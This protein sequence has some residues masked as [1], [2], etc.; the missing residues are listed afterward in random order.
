M[1]KFFKILFSRIAFLLIAFTLQI[2]F[3]IFS[4]LEF[5][6]YFV[7]F[8]TISIVLSILLVLSLI[9]SNIVPEYK[10]AWIIPIMLFPAFGWILYI[11][12]SKPNFNK[13][14]TKRERDYYKNMLQEFKTLHKYDTSCIEELEKENIVALN[15]AK[16]LINYGRSFIFNNSD[17]KYYSV[18][19]EYFES[20]LKE[21]NKAE[22]FIFMEYFIIQEG[23]MWDS[24]LE[25]L[26]NKVKQGVEVRVIFDDFG[27]ITTLPKN[28]HKTLEKY[29]I[30]CTVFNP[31]KIIFAP[32]YNNRTHRKI[33]V[34]DGKVA[35]TGG[36]NL[37][38]EYI[39][40]VVRFGHWKDTGISMKG[41]GVW[42][43][44]IMFLTNWN[45][46]N[47]TSENFLKFKCP[48]NT[49]SV[50]DGYVIPFSDSPL[51]NEFVGQNVY[52][53][54]IQ[55]A[56]KYI[57]INTPYLIVGHEI[58][59]ALCYAVKRGVEVKICTPHIPDKKSVFEVTRS[60]YHSLIESGV[61]IY[62]YTPGFLH[63]KSFIVDDQYAVIGTIN[64]DYRSLYLH[65]ECG[66]WIYN[67]KVIFDM[68]KDYFKTLGLCT[69]ISIEDCEKV[70]GLRKLY[71]SILKVFAPLM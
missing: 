45:F 33:T 12:F 24:I 8:N 9:S 17:T 69:K 43:F 44:T 1:K 18:G 67:S 40:K 47:K 11:L 50:K 36:I 46:I 19:E 53:S 49:I 64:L 23:E 28:Y 56:T 68:K 29:G 48:E 57:Y 58:I 65:F 55:N 54:L 38:D 71:R 66:L 20:L 51:D 31:A 10:I 13:I 60:N 26:K 30:K 59:N 22:K 15:Q 3:V 32:I 27:C 6:K 52:L 2:L 35:F 62:E 14:T 70:S 21:L 7:Y 39:N 4:I 42:G 63:A 25:V 41:E 37:S 5:Q 34:I 16:Y 61:E